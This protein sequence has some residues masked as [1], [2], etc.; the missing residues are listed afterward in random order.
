MQKMKRAIAKSWS[1][2]GA[3][4]PGEETRD[5]SQE[6]A[7]I[8]P[9]RAHETRRAQ[10]RRA[11]DPQSKGRRPHR[12]VLSQVMSG[13]LRIGA[14]GW[15]S[16]GALFLALSSRLPFRRPPR[17]QGRS[18]RE[19]ILSAMRNRAMLRLRYEGHFGYLDIEPH[20]L[21]RNAAGK[22]L[23]WCYEIANLQEG[24]TCGGWHLL[25]VSDIV[26][27]Y[28]SGENFSARPWPG[29]S[30]FEILIARVDMSAGGD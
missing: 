29:E 27:A 18:A 4:P 23:L 15:S 7:T 25:S 9:L 13:I 16:L 24:E 11:K 1:S 17:T 20:G 12:P 10:D 26:T 8:L 30:H 3:E 19:L 21:G 28:P 14:R 6:S 5:A 2:R 22:L